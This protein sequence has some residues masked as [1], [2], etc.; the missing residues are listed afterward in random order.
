[1]TSTMTNSNKFQKLYKFV[2]GSSLVIFTTVAAF[3][4]SI[5]T[6]LNYPSLLV[7][8]LKPV[9]QHF[10]LNLDRNTIQFLPECSQ[11]DESL[12]Y[13]LKP[14]TCQFKNREFDINIRVNSAG[15]RDSE[16]DLESPE[17]IVIGDSHAMAWGIEQDNMFSSILETTLDKSILNTAISSYGTVRELE[18]L[19]RVNLNKVETLIIQYC[20]N[21]ISENEYFYTNNNAIDIMSKSN[22]D[23]LTKEHKETTQYYFG[24]YS[25]YTAKTIIQA[26]S[27]FI[28]NKSVEAADAQAS[29]DIPSEAELFINVLTHS[30]VDISAFNI[31]VFEINGKA[32]NDSDFINE[33]K[34][35]I[36]RD[37]F[38][39]W[40]KN[41][42]PVDVSPFLT[43]DVYYTLDDHSKPEAHHLIA[44]KLAETLSQKN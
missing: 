39:T 13:L 21:D 2:I 12:S 9:I 28:S 5:V 24:K 40:I 43:S 14:G 23:A 35:T 29:T 15:F 42:T 20:Q 32:K 33:L 10:H 4:L 18:T 31:I 30:P 37:D 1:V 16:A 8:G 34:A 17:I 7:G 11:Y 19:T 38:P 6:L 22:Y 41:I 44:K 36:S 26:A 25:V 3:E 27:E